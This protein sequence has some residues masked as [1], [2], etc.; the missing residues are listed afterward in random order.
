M[1]SLPTI[2]ALLLA[3]GAGWPGCQE[4]ALEPPCPLAGTPCGG[5]G[6]VACLPEGLVCEPEVPGGSCE[7]LVEV[8]QVTGEPDRLTDHGSGIAFGD[9]DGDGHVDAAIGT[10][11]GLVLLRGDGQ[12]G[13]EVLRSADEPGPDRISGLTA[14]DYDGDSDLDLVFGAQEPPGLYVLR[15]T[16]GGEFEDITNTL[17]L[18]ATEVP[19]GL[20]WGDVD[21]DS[22]LDLFVAGYALDPSLLLRNLGGAGFESVGAQAGIP[23]VRPSF[24]GVW[25]D[26]DL[27]GD[28]DLF[29]SNDNRGRFENGV[30]SELYR[31]DGD[32][33]LTNV[34]EA[35]GITHRIDGMGIGLGD[36]DGDARL[37]IFVTNSNGMQGGS[38]PEDGQL[39][40]LA[41][42][43]R[44]EEAGARLGLGLQ[45]RTAWGV[46]VLDFDNDADNDVVLAAELFAGAWLGQN[47]GGTFVGVDSVVDVLPVLESSYG[48]ASADFDHDGRLDLGWTMGP[49]EP[50]A[51]LARN[52]APWA[53]HW[54]RVRLSDT[55]PNRHGIGALVYADI[56]GHRQVRP[57]TAGGSHLSCS[58]AVAHFGLG[59][60]VAAERVVVRWTDGSETTREGPLAAGVE[61][62]VKRQL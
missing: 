38:V 42:G 30:P 58:E 53:G 44:F 43:D 61:L 28:L 17:G 19:R 41:R 55:G 13:F 48:L 46:E 34:S 36:L 24:Q 20:S 5:C 31:N 14:V 62:L 33:V 26:Y 23:P 15:N 10:T 11:G 29:V 50:S 57:I 27:D 3:G 8:A 2:L 1:R 25:L 37:D 56:D 52:V 60:A 9:L 45:D 39:V 6:V 21:G 7:S 18:P 49:F 22:W 54:L 12:G 47:V 16:G 51:R 32:L 4:A 40:Y 35:V 59:E